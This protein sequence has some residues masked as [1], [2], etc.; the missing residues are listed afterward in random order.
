MGGSPRVS[1]AP[2]ENGFAHVGSYAPAPPTLPL[3]GGL[4]HRLL[5]RWA[6]AFVRDA[7]V[8]VRRLGAAPCTACFA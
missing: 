2:S 4:L 3:S 5:A 1:D 8:V 7:R 6:A